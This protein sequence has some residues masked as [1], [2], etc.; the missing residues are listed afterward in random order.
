MPEDYYQILGISR[1]C[2]QAEIKRAYRRLA[3][4]Y[5]P[6]VCKDD[7]AEDRFKEIGRAYA[8]L[9]DPEKRQ[10]Y[11]MYG[12]EG[13]T[14]NG[15]NGAPTDI[16]DLFNQV[17]GGAGGPFG[18]FSAQAQAR[19]ADLHYE[20][21][22]DLEGVLNGF[23]AEL[24]VSRQAECDDCG[25]SGAAAGSAP[26]T[27]DMCG[28]RGYVAR[29]RQTLLGV[30]AT[31]SACPRC[32]GRGTVVNDPC[33][34][35][36]GQGVTRS[37]Q[38]VLVSIPPGIQH[39]QR[40]RMAGHGDVPP[41]G[42]IPGDLLVG[43]RVQSHPDFS[44]SDRDL[45]MDLDLSFSQAALGDTIT[46]PTLDG[47]TEITIRPGAQTGDTVEL[48][49]EGLPPLHGGRRGRQIINL[50]VVTPTDLDEEQRKLL[51]ELA[52]RRGESIEPAEQARL[53]D[54]I[55]KVLGGEA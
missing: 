22:I 25:G 44:R 45:L 26:A 47:E 5:H 40:I 53:F 32:E 38:K 31:T 6:D 20:V 16:F 4:R 51:M 55:R 48:S 2:D 7:G 49:G 3:R 9:S 12:E 35:C 39:G 21:T 43:V 8:V 41:G 11:D 34:S 42:G 1:D 30:M 27:C 24:E 19:G 46:V 50:R 18:G 15:N 52:L 54:R 28:G 17:F 29:Q 14:G 13:V 36:R 33:E 37:E 23:E 10:R